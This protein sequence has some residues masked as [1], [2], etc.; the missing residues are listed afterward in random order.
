MHKIRILHPN[1]IL[2]M[3][4]PVDLL[5]RSNGYREIWTVGNEEWL[6]GRVS[7]M[8]VSSCLRPAQ[9]PQSQVWLSWLHLEYRWRQSQQLTPGS[10]VQ[11]R[12]TLKQPSRHFESRARG[13]VAA[14]WADGV[15]IRSATP[16]NP[17]KRPFTTMQLG[18]TV[19]SGRFMAIWFFGYPG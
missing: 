12:P 4:L 9:W 3:Y 16:C 13:P 6:A 14:T 10:V 1:S 11:P 7:K 5:S 8:G 19:N 15:S 18:T 17:S 2:N